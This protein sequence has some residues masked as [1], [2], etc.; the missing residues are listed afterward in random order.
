MLKSCSRVIRSGAIPWL[1]LLAAGVAVAL[2]CSAPPAS[3]DSAPD[4]LRALA[5]EK[6]PTYPDDTIAV[7]LLDEL[8]TT[9]ADNGQITTRHRIAYKL[10]RPQAKERYGYAGVAFDN[11]T[12]IMSFNAWTITADGHEF[13]LKDKDSLERSTTT[14][15]VF[16]DDKEKLQR[17]NEANPGSV[18]GYEYVQKQ[19]PFIFEDDWQFQDP[20]PLRHGRL[21]LQLPPGW[22]FTTRWF[23]YAEQKPVSSGNNQ[24]VWE[25]ND[26]PAVDTEPEMPPWISV[27][28]WV[29]L[30]YFPHDPAMRARTTGSWNDLGLWYAGLTQNSRAAS[31]EIKQKV[32]EL[33]AG[34][35][36][37][38][39]KMRA[40]T[41]YVQ[42][43]IRYVAIEL[44]IG[45]YQ[46]HPAADTF[47]HQ[48]GD[49]KDKATLLSAMLHE[50]GIESYYV[51]VD[52]DRG[53]VRAD[54]P[55]MHFDH[56][57]VAIRLPDGL[58]A[59]ALYAVVN[60]PKL[61]RLLF[62][63]PTNEYVP[64][65]YLPWY[66][67]N[68]SG[69]VVSSDGGSLIAMPLLPP[70]TNRLLRT[71]TLTLTAAGDLS[72]EV[73]EINWGGPASAERE[74]FMETQPS[75]RFDLVT[76]FL[77]QFLNNYTVTGA[78]TNNLEK[79]DQNLVL[80]Y[81][82]VSLGYA[83]VS[84]DMLF[85][86]P[87]VV[88]D[89]DSNMLKLFTQKKPRKYQIE[90]EEATRQDDLIDITLPAEYVVDGLPPPVQAD[91]DYASYKSETTV[92]DGVLHYKRTFEIKG[93]EVPTEKLPEIRSFL[94]QVAEDQQASAVLKRKNP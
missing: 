15:E 16:S 6:L 33:T 46:P 8:Q 73:N 40:L 27:A 42:K 3:A 41:E 24:Y 57:I 60:D 79:Y 80:D 66:L 84:G 94:R 89:K 9:V 65:G 61:G 58:D 26:V 5:Q 28:G 23:N 36:D 77:G 71:A 39:A 37:P 50:A 1:A 35:T 72:G 19:R 32:A 52:D 30:K 76:N 31:P 69:L 85:L 29:G 87:R 49:C 90:F 12:K 55:S 45:G 62:F 18:V 13:A 82:F 93:V 17:F 14:Y 20:M 70:S 7:E 43:N 48:Y 88:G 34:M 56:V 11:E 21:V 51:V 47:T 54:Y 81:K 2:L 83:N 78:V 75:K 53:I 63:D 10:L 44:G 92:A 68:N 38:I 25:V 67:Q 59:N 86:R 22:D 91:C 64:L 74:Q 4:W